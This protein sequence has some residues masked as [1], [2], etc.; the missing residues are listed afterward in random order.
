MHSQQL[1]TCPHC[2]I[3]LVFIKKQGFDKFDECFVLAFSLHILIV[4]SSTFMQLGIFFAFA[5][6]RIPQTYNLSFWI[7]G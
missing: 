3:I 2:Q 6:V 1:N 7:V 5:G 4:G